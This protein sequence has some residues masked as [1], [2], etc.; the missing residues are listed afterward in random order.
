MTR[1]SKNIFACCERNLAKFGPSSGVTQD[2]DIWKCPTCG[3]E[4]FHVCDEAEG[5]CW[6]HSIPVQREAEPKERQ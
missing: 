6:E 1:K 2:G 5:C 4:F 3:E